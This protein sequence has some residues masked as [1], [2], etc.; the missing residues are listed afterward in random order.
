MS[1]DKTY[2]YKAMVYIMGGSCWAR[3]ETKG[4]AL[5]ELKKL[6]KADWSHIID[7]DRWIASGTAEVDLYEDANTDKHSD[8][9]FIA[10]V[11]LI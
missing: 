6:L 5:R 7:V 1:E 9:T 2:K 8:D 11:P 4:E 3:A 10:H